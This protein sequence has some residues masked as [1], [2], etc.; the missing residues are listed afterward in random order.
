M[1][2]PIYT[3]ILFAVAGTAVIVGEPL[4]IIAFFLILAAYLWKIWT[5]EK[6]LQEEFGAAYTQDK[7]EVPDSSRFL[8]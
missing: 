4:G 5:E 7:M 3:G 8:Y 1:W 6:Y 2:H